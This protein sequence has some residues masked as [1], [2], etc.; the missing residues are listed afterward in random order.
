MFGDS[1]VRFQIQTVLKRLELLWKNDSLELGA[2][3]DEASELHKTIA[4][5]GQPKVLVAGKGMLM[6]RYKKAEAARDA[7]KAFQSF[8]GWDRIS[9]YQK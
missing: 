6:K 1:E 7:K 2:F 8:G 4:G 3:V 9:R 5:L